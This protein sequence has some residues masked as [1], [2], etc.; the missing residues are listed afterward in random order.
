M[1]GDSGQS[2]MTD[3]QLFR[4]VENWMQFWQK[5]GMEGEKTNWEDGREQPVDVIQIYGCHLY[6]IKAD[7]IHT[8]LGRSLVAETS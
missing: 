2:S 7:L 1:S 4:Q 3:G 5:L 8:L 6:T